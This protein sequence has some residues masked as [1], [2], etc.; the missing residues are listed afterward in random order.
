MWNR[1]D[2]RV[3]TGIEANSMR[4]GEQFM[5][6]GIRLALAGLIMVGALSGCMKKENPAAGTAGSAAGEA[7]KTAETAAPAGAPDDL[8]ET[9]TL[10]ITHGAYPQT[11]DIQNQSD[12]FSS[13]PAGMIFETLMKIDPAG[14]YVPVLAEQWEYVDDTHLKFHLRKNVK[15]HNGDAMTAE[16]VRWS[17]IRAANSSHV[18]SKAAFINTDDIVIEDDHTLIVGYKYPNASAYSAYSQLGLSILPSG[19]Y[20][21]ADTADISKNPIGTGPYKYVGCVNGE[22]VTFVRNDEYW[23]EP[24]KIKNMVWKTITENANRTIELETGGAHFSYDIPTTDIER[25]DSDSKMSLL[26]GPNFTIQYVCYNTQKAP[27]H[28]VRVRKALGMAVDKE[29]IRIAAYNGIGG[30]GVGPMVST[31]T[32]ATEELDVADYDL[33]AAKALLAE[34]GYPDGFDIKIYTNENQARIDAAQVVQNSWAKIGVRATVT[35]LEY[36]AYYDAVNTGEYD[37]CFFG[38]VSNGDPD[39][40]LYGL[41]HS[42]MIGA[43]NYSH[44]DN[45]RVDELLEAGRK[46]LDD[47]KREQIYIDL[48]KEL[49]DYC[50]A[51][52]YW[53][54]VNVYAYSNELMPIEYTPYNFEPWTYEWK[55]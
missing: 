28:D 31:T 42:S 39:N 6:K 17:L 38:W 32:Y 7:A 15:F 3:I 19:L 11:L 41:Y 29:A 18:S 25:V 22:S 53:Q 21:D 48:Q 34:A 8:N 49:V 13:R 36:A 23:G 35:T 37:V 47:S 46:E 24:A 44:T 5:K 54:G 50:P 51:T 20:Q 55:K 14:N 16:D 43:S 26:M 30:L 33:E 4:K 2:S 27:F 1:A 52:Y 45:P 10:V 12:V 40:T 9:K